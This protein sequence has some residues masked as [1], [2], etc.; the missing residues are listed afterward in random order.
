MA[1]S[2][3]SSNLI[4]SPGSPSSIAAS[5]TATGTLTLT[6]GQL[7]G[8]IYVEVIIGSSAPGT[9][10]TVQF[11]ISTDGTN[12]YA[13]GGPYVVPLTVSTSNAYE[14]SGPIEAVALQVVITNGTT[15]AITAYAQAAVITGP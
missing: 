7:Q 9:N 2:R 6:T 1:V 8:G 5:A 14:L 11:N 13:Y 15:N 12:F 4:G 3:S 10:P